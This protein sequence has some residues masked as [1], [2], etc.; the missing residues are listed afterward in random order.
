MSS[1]TLESVMGTRFF[2]RVGCWVPA[3]PDTERCNAVTHTVTLPADF[4]ISS[5]CMDNPDIFRCRL[6]RGHE[7]YHAAPGITW[8][9]TLG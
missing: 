6:R 1:Q 7:G 4:P 3:P 8:L 9:E 5:I 2:W